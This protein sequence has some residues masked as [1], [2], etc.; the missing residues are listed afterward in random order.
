MFQR[1]AFQWPTRAWI[2]LAATAPFGLAVAPG[3]S[4]QVVDGSVKASQAATVSQTI[5]E[6]EITVV[7]NRPV[8][9]GRVLYGNLVPWGLEWNPGADQ[10]T[11]I[12]TTQDLLLAGERL[13]AGNYSIWA[14]P[15]PDEWTI[16]LHRDW[17]VFHA[18]YPG[19]EGVELRLDIEPV[20]AAHVESLAF[21][22]PVADRRDGTLALHWGETLLLIPL[23]VPEP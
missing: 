15:N 2:F 13:P 20:A 3:A 17:D 18:P 23:H 22:F 19:D 8:A 16:I 6:A 21:Y 1:P 14:I 4:A 7:Y 5:A 9:R 11:H 10:A 12:K